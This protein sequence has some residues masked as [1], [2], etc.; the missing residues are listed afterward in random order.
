[1][2]GSNYSNA[3]K[4]DMSGTKSDWW[5]RSAPFSSFTDFSYVSDFGTWGNTGSQYTTIG[6]SP[7][8]RIAN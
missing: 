4:K 6:V 7:A 5:L 3:I 8:F 2:T 1:M